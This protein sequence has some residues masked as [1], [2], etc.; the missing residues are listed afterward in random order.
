MPE[1]ARFALAYQAQL[2]ELGAQSKTAHASRVAIH[3]GEV[4]L[5]ENA[6]AD[7]ARGAKPL[8]VEGQ[9]KTSRA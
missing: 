3:L 8:E 4:V 5:R 7:I 2:V 6:A 9:A 1:A